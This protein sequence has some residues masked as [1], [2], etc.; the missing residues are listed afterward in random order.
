MLIEIKKSLNKKLKRKIF[1]IFRNEILKYV[2]SE[3]APNLDAQ[4]KFNRIVLPQCII[5]YKKLEI[6]T[7]LPP[8]GFI[9][10]NHHEQFICNA[11]SRIFDEFVKNVEF[12]S[13]T[14]FNCDLG[15][16]KVLRATVWIGKCKDI[17]ISGFGVRPC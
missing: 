2:D 11:E 1:K 3:F 6:K 16:K 15:H 9:D 12:D 10:H 4:M 14:A 7:D 5:E 17:K 8:D 13:Y